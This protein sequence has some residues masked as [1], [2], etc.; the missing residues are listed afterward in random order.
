TPAPSALAVDSFGRVLLAGGANSGNAVAGYQL[1]GTL[2]VAFGNGG[3]TAI[4]PDATVAAITVDAQGNII[5]VGSINDAGTRIPDLSRPRL[6]PGGVADQTFGQAGT[7]VVKDLT[8]TGSFGTGIGVDPAT[9]KLIALAGTADGYRFVR[10][11]T[12]GSVDTTFGN[13]SGW[14]AF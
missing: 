10:F 14:V 2:D 3:L 4:S 12:D 7:A 5:L 9:G 1:D 11:K 13:G 8:P 6:N